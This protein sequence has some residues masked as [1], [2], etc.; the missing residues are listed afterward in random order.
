MNHRTI[1]DSPQSFYGANQSPITKSFIPI[2]LGLVPCVVAQKK[3]RE[4]AVDRFTGI[5]P[6]ILLLLQH[7]HVFTLG[8]F[9][10]EKDLTVSLESLAQEGISLVHTDRGGSITY[11]GPGQLV[12]YPIINLKESALNVREY[13]W[14]LEEVVLR[15]LTEY[16]IR[17]RRNANLPGV[18]IGD[19]KICSIGI[20]VEH[21]ITTHG[22]AFN[23]NTDLS[24]FDKINPCGLHGNVMTSLSVILGSQ[25]KVESVIEPLIESFSQI[26]GLIRRGVL[27]DWIPSATRMVKIEP[28]KFRYA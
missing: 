24:Y 12:G 18:W 1:D 28:Y 26:F 4:L 9:R 14:S 21:F 15:L 2:Y 13:V 16:G 27:D 3:Q 8:R 25:M 22:F 10:G 11:H 6:D 23:V 5:V 7:P 17:G 19:Q 20:H